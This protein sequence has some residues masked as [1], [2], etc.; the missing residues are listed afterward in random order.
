M[1]WKFST[2]PR[3]Q[4]V[5]IKTPW[6]PLAFDWYAD[7]EVNSGVGPLVWPWVL[8]RVIRGQG[9][10]SDKEFDP[11]EA[12]RNV[13]L[14]D[15]AQ[16]LKMALAADPD[17]DVQAWMVNEVDTVFRA[18]Q[19]PRSSR[20]QP[21]LVPA[22][23]ERDMG[24]RNR[25][26]GY[27]RNVQVKRGLTTKSF[28]DWMGRF[29][30]VQVIFEDPHSSRSSAPPSPPPPSAPPSGSPPP[31]SS[32]P[33]SQSGSPPPHSATVAAGRIAAL[34]HTY[35]PTVRLEPD[36]FTD[37]MPLLLQHGEVVVA[38]TCAA[39]KDKAKHPNYMI[40][41][42]ARRPT[43]EAPSERPVSTRPAAAPA[44]GRVPSRDSWE[45]YP[46]NG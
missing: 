27:G 39:V 6:A 30:K 28:T 4:I 11:Q 9:V 3:G 46:W 16:R 36:W 17:L 12:A 34:L 40:A 35:W 43:A 14:L 24:G 21:L 5:P 8:G 26:G 29:T 37:N 2:S 22:S 33:N 45:E 10:I 38:Q 20:K 23:S 31:S 42:L 32:N 44:A 25:Q 15:L 41:C 7:E 13:G 19:R 1:R 18:W